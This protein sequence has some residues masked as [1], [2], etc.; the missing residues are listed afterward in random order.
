MTAPPRRQLPECGGP[1][2]CER[3]SPR[4]MESGRWVTQQVRPP[5]G[6][7]QW[8]LSYVRTRGGRV[9][10]HRALTPAVGLT[11]ALAR[12]GRQ[13]PPSCLTLEQESD[14]ATPYPTPPRARTL[15]ARA[16]RRSPPSSRRAAS[17][18]VPRHR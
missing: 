18:G 15:R 12:R 1:V 11:R 2:S 16:P 4:S 6:H 17:S 5:H 9:S 7:V 14:L 3:G 10:L 13:H 8:A